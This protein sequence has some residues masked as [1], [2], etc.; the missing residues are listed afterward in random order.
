L[1]L[2]ETALIEVS[3]TIGASDGA[4]RPDSRASRDMAETTSEQPEHFAALLNDD[5]DEM[6]IQTGS[7][8]VDPARDRDTGKG[9]AD[10][11]YRTPRAGSEDP[12]RAMTP[13]EGE[14]EGEGESAVPSATGSVE[15]TPAPTKG[16][17]KIQMRERE[18]TAPRCR[19]V[20]H[21]DDA[22]DKVLMGI[23]RVLI[24]SGNIPSTPKELTAMIL[25]WKI[26]RMG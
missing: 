26:V 22:R 20:V 13:G 17:W 3:R 7:I 21:A 18:K 5:E 6:D 8:E 4:D 23:V 24:K 11:G 1:K 15:G 12:R 10:D 19:V 25:H 9:R 2:P 14:G 16:L